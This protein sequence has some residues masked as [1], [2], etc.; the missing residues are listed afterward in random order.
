MAEILSQDEVNALLRGISSGAI[1]S[2]KKEENV[3]G[4]RPYDLTSQDRIVRGRMPTL[5]IIN[6]RFA[7]LLRNDLTS[8]LRKVA[9]ITA[10]SVDMQKFGEFLKNIPLPTSLTIFKMPPLRGYAIFVLDS[11]LVYNLIDIFFGGTTDLH[12]KIEGRDFSPIEN[13]LIK[14][15]TDMAFNALKTA[16]TPVSPIDIEFQRSEINPQFATIVTPT[17]VVIISRFEVD[18]EGAVSKFMICIPYSMVEPIKEKL[19]SGFQSEQLEVDHRWIER[20]KERLKESELNI[21]IDVGKTSISS[22]D[23]LKIKKGDVIVLDKRIEDPL[24]VDIENL[25]KFIAYPGKINNNIAVKIISDIP[26][27]KEGYYE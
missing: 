20:F 26:L 23:F 4:I 27:G 1:E 18:I 3:G 6:E 8:A 19:Y 12:V 11:R 5:E 22:R 10:T 16:W 13:K 7:R 24:V 14:K 9:E 25:P 17:E 2:E 15:I 21:R